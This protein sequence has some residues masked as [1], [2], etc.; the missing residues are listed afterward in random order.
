M[1]TLKSET[2]G[3]RLYAVTR[4]RLER[5]AKADDRTLSQIARKAIEEGLPALE[6]KLLSKTSSVT[7]TPKSRRAA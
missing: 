7:E 6:A 2:L 4:E 1:K 3:V 5:L